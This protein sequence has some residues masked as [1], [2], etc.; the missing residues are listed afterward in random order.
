[1]KL[2]KLE[3]ERID[4]LDLRYIRHE[5]LEK[6]AIFDQFL[7]SG[8]NVMEVVFGEDDCKNVETIRSSMKNAIKRFGYHDRIVYKVRRGK[9]YLVRKDY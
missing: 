3:T 8:E 7:E 4:D 9:A 2:V 5:T 6:K 1:M